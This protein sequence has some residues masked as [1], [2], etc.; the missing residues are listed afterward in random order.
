MVIDMNESRLT[1]V[2]QLRAFL[3]GTLEVQFQPL[4]DNQQRY[5]MNASDSF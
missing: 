1:T 4:N 2:E 3:A 5:A